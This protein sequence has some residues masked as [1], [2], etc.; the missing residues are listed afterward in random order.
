[1]HAAL[2]ILSER[3]DLA[4]SPSSG[5]P[6]AGAVGMPGPG[7]SA[8]GSRLA[9]QT[10]AGTVLAEAGAALAVRNASAEQQTSEGGR[11]PDEAVQ[12]PSM[13]GTDEVAAQGSAESAPA[14]GDAALDE[15]QPEG[16]LMCDEAGALSSIREKSEADTQG[17]A[18]AESVLVA[19]KA[20]PQEGP[21][22][23]AAMAT[24]STAQQA[25]AAALDEE[26]AEP[27]LVK[28]TAHAEQ[29][30]SGKG[31]VPD[32]AVAPVSTHRKAE[33]DAQDEGV[34]QSALAACSAPADE[35]RS[36][37]VLVPDEAHA[38]A[39]MQETAGSASQDRGGARS[40]PAVGSTPADEHKSEEVVM[41]DEPQAPASM[42][43]TAR[44][45]TQS[46]GGAQSALAARSTPADEHNSEELLMLDEAEAPASMQETAR[47][48]SQREGGAQ[49]AGRIQDAPA[50]DKGSGAELLPEEAMPVLG[51]QKV[52]HAAAQ[53]AR[54]QQLDAAQV[55]SHALE[56]S[57]G[58]EPAANVSRKRDRPIDLQKLEETEKPARGFAARLEGPAHVIETP[59]G[60]RGF[61]AEPAR[62]F[63]IASPQAAAPGLDIVPPGA[64]EALHGEAQVS[65][66][67]RC[68]EAQG[69]SKMA[70]CGSSGKP[71]LQV[72]PWAAPDVLASDAAHSSRLHTTPEGAQ[73]ELDG[74]GAVEQAARTRDV[75]PAESSAAAAPDSY[76]QNSQPMRQVDVHAHAADEREVA[77]ALQGPARALGA[78][79]LASAELLCDEVL[80]EADFG[81][82]WHEATEAAS[83]S[84]ANASGRSRLGQPLSGPAATKAACTADGPNA[85][86]LE[87]EQTAPDNTFVAEEAG[88]T[89]DA[90]A[91]ALGSAQQEAQPSPQ[92]AGVNS[93]APEQDPS[94]QPS[95]MQPGT[96]FGASPRIAAALLEA[97]SRITVRGAKPRRTTVSVNSSA[98]AAPEAVQE[99]VGVVPTADPAHIPEVTERVK[100][101]TPIK[102]SDARVPQCSH[103]LL[104][105][106][107]GHLN[108]TLPLTAT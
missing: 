33:A 22:P 100:A 21:R 55:S 92:V 80:P 84:P 91:T 74:P 2:R 107:F 104:Q 68:G 54:L 9:K 26:G 19:E 89:Q 82:P 46:E 43:E 81:L 102:V 31:L 32:E 108:V 93:V 63:D 8:A 57:A 41:P 101:Q 4:A 7:R 47:P 23:D 10:C 14:V 3:P 25:E 18:D 6:A 97:G 16:R 11:M 64:A 105:H 27:A 77:C 51:S 24:R 40:A 20:P 76:V 39:S 38:P 61:L 79:K 34:T 71:G 28:G 70:H 90:A 12:A 49:S 73:G 106:F 88:A 75:A 15:Q 50:G 56:L 52:I 60:R 42:Q 85:P 35:L 53:N 78:R 44:P 86:K 29:Q 83:D 103:A 62:L 87:A 99:G 59:Q 65:A 96:A 45:A 36:E 30:A 95:N 67:E 13:P 98:A 17:S 37:E 66:A 5:S 1:M 48:A 58:L 94:G 72:L 69:V